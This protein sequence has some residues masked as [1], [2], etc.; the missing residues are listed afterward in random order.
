MAFVGITV[1]P[2]GTDVV[3]LVGVAV[4]GSA[5]AVSDGTGVGVM[6]GVNVAR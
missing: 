2:V 4:G 1:P 5:V 6:V 3:S